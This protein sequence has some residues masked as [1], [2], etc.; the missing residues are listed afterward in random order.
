M[1]GSNT[2]IVTPDQPSGG[3]AVA[4]QRALQ[5]LILLRDNFCLSAAGAAIATTKS[6][7]QIVNTVVYL[8]DGVFKSKGATDNFWVL[9]VT[10]VL[11]AG[12]VQ[13]WQLCLNAA[14]TTVVV[15]GVPATTAAG[16]TF[17]DVTGADGNVYPS[18]GPSLAVVSILQVTVNS[19]TFTPATTLL[20][21]AT[22][23]TTYTDGYSATLYGAAIPFN[24]Q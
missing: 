19:S 5:A 15:A 11:T 20:D 23:T 7:V 12:Q 24:R 14:G 2:V 21:A 4:C 16:V 10:P 6:K 13:K 18:P 22:I 3:I 9:P 8:I 17:A 1:A